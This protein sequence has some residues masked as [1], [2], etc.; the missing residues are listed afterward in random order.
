MATARQQIR[1]A[2]GTQLTGLT[3]TGARVYMSR[4]YPLSESNLPALRIFV[5]RDSYSEA[6]S[7]NESEWRELSIVVEAIARAVADV[8]DTL[9]TICGEVGDAVA[10]NETL[11][12]RVKWMQNER[13]DF[14]ITDDGD[15]PFGMAVMRYTAHY[16]VDPENPDTIL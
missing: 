5:E 9:D 2:L 12:G 11:T 7:S 10:S 13:I 15:R 6:Y 4:V 14:E 3:T 8:D 16:V 1:D